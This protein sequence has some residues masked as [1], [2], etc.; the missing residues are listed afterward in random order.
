MSILGTT[1]AADDLG[2]LATVAIGLSYV[3]GLLV[4]ANLGDRRQSWRIGA[5]LMLAF[6]AV[7][8]ALVAIAGMATLLLFGPSVRPSGSGVG[9]ARQLSGGLV[10]LSGASLALASLLPQVRSGVSR[11]LSGFRPESAINAVALGLYFGTL[12]TF[13]SFQVSTDQLKEISASGESPSLWFIIVTNQLPFVILA[14]FGVGFLTRRSLGET[15]L[16]LGLYWPGWRWLIGSVGVAVL[17][18]VFDFAFGLVMNQVTPQQSQEVQRVSEQLLRNVNGYVPAI[19]LALAAGIGEEVLFR[20]ALLPRLGNLLSALLFAGLH[21]QY[22]LS[23]ATFEIFVLGLVLGW[24]RRRAGTTGAIVA[25]A[26]YDTILL[27][28]AIAL[29]GH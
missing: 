17:L 16:R 8:A 2:Q 1:L 29:A 24:L 7:V 22:A 19:I 14:V 10:L 28:M 20:G 6:P 12:L 18:V 23:L 5:Y 13:L 3:V 4:A 9:L 27:V 25:H 21:A 15:A 26:A 11:V